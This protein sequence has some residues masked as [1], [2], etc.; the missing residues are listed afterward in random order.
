MAN[1]GR[2]NVKREFRITKANH[3]NLSKVLMLIVYMFY[4]QFVDS[5]FFCQKSCQLLSYKSDICTLFLPKC[6]LTNVRSRF[7]ADEQQVYPR[8]CLG[9]FGRKTCTVSI[10][11]THISY[12]NTS[13]LSLEVC[14]SMEY[15]LNAPHQI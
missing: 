8:L 11:Y 6:A 7:S 4:H 3:R 2:T 12:T 13:I 5:A 10:T 9:H 14:R 1:E 15:W